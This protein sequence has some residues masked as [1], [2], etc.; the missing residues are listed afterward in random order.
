VSEPVKRGPIA[1]MA[2]NSVASNLGMLICFAAGGAGLF[3]IK[4]EVFPEFT[5]DIVNVTVP[6]PGASPTEVEQGIVFAIEEAVRGLDGVK[7]VNSVASEGAASVSVELLLG[8]DPDKVL[9]EIKNEVDR[10][11][12]FPEDAEKP[13]IAVVSRKREVISLVLYGEQPLSTLH[14]LAERVRSD[15]LS[16]SGVTQVEVFGVPPVEVSIEIPRASLEAY[17][18][19]LEQVAHRIRAASVELPGGELETSSG[20]IL[21]RVADR[22]RDGHEFEDVVLRSTASGHEVRLSDIA[23]IRD[24][25]ADDDSASYFNGLPAVRVTAYRV[26]AET[27]MDVASAVKA[28]A[29]QLRYDLPDEVQVETWKDDSELLSARL[30]LLLR[31][32]RMGL[33]L[34]VFI[35]A[36]FLKPRLAGWVAMGIPISFLGAL[37]ILPGMDVS[38]NMVTTF[39][40][41]VTLGLVVDDAIVVGENVTTKLEAG[42]P[43]L[44]AAIEGAQEMAVPVTFSVLT[45]LAA[46]SP[47]FFVPGTMGKVFRLIPSVVCA[48][49]VFSLFESF[50]ILPAHLA[51]AS[52]GGGPLDRVFAPLNWAQERCSGFL[53]TMIQRAYRPTLRVVLEYRYVTIAG[54][55]AMF[56]MTVGLVAAGLVPFSF[57][58]R[59]EGDA[60]TA[61]ARLPYGAP[62][63]RTR[64]IQ[65]ILERAAAGA[66]EEAG[67]QSVVRGMFTHLG[68]G[69][70]RDGPDAGPRLAGSHLVTVELNL[71]G[72][73]DREFSGKDFAAWWQKNTP[74]IPGLE[75]LVFNHGMGLGAGAA[76]DVQLSHESMEVLGIASTA[77]TQRLREY[78]AL[79][80]VENSHAAGK[81]Q[82][83]FHLRPQAMQVGLT[84]A[85]VARQLRGAFFGIEALREQR[86]RNEVKVMVRLPYE[87][88]RSEDDLD[89]LLVGT[90]V[91]GQVPLSF[92]SRFERGKSPTAIKREEG[93]RIINVVAQLAPAAVTA[94]DVL[95]SLEEEVLPALRAEHPGLSTELVGQQRSQ[96]DVFGALRRNFGLAMFAIFALLAVPFRSYIQPFIV[97]S[98]IPFGFVGAVLGHGLMGF[99]LSLISMF[100]IIALSGVVVNDSLVLIDATNRATRAGQPPHLAIVD[101]ASRRVRP[102]LLTSL[103]TFFG[104]APMILETSPQARFLVPMAISLGYG[105]LFAT[106]IV[107]IFVPAAYLVAEDVRSLAPSKRHEE[108]EEPA[109]TTA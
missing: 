17:G 32:A 105:V 25:F 82:L 98:A 75:A 19:T 3:S 101:G 18:L 89:R 35:L 100:G 62:L 31:N 68:A 28:Y 6:Y 39:A 94:Q 77:L 93:K 61:H 47:L 86:G 34:V 99:E 66:I 41:I 92:V 45:T 5:L 58:P 71:V 1:W 15:L 76:V 29:E 78:T 74:T 107:L 109:P 33:L 56:M 11:Q 84:G 67:G 38:V 55:L 8:A 96:G 42:V 54:A 69:P 85:D 73:E 7:L 16:S 50:F 95:R 2:K 51:H 23:T 40:F 53:A 80:N 70:K 43:K 65:K 26:G 12:S 49:L 14:A 90:P 91:G 4:Q 27:P 37:A 52:T 108:H 36:L 46:F 44:R 72:S 103:T 22:R 83:D 97:M 30:D 88:R 64:E 20:E 60:V 104:L 79:T 21:V 10:I 48:V 13:T 81:P 59:L 63:E 9:N 102:I 24:G 87:Q 57:F 106:F